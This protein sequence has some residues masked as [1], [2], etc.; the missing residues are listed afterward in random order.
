MVLISGTTPTITFSFNEISPSNITKAYLVI[1]SLGRTLIEKD[2]DDATV[3]TAQTGGTV[4]WQLTQEDT[5]KLR[6]CTRVDIG[7]DWK[8]ADGTR[9]RSTV[10]TYDIEQSRKNETI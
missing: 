9:G 5:L 1:K 4:A 10:E 7:C 3:T 6:S 2:L 8:L